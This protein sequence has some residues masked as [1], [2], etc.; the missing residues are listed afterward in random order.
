MKDLLLLSILV[1]A[2]VSMHAQEQTRTLTAQPVKQETVAAK[3][4][5][6]QKVQPAPG[7]ILTNETDSLAGETAAHCDAVIAAIDQKIAYV[8]A[9]PEM[10]GRAQA[11]GWFEKMAGYRANYVA[12]K[13]ALLLREEQH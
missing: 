13:E 8:Q 9:D 6:L 3:P 5:K 10:S 12:R 4:I 11:N 7:T 1:F 2:S